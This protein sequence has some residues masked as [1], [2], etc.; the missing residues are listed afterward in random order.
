MEPG[1]A[2][3]RPANDEQ[4]GEAENDAGA[5]QSRYNGADE[6]P[7]GR[8]LFFFDFKKFKSLDFNVLGG[9]KVRVRLFR[10]FWVDV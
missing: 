6:E 4:N 8:K 2:W 3:V 5:E 9:W 10:G 7:D 1:T